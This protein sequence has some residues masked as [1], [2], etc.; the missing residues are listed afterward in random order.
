[1]TG[2]N[3]RA[4]DVNR[5]LAAVAEAGGY[6]IGLGSQRA[7]IAGGRLDP[8]V[9]A[10]YM[11][12]DV[13]PTT[14]IFANLGAVQAAVVPTAL[15]DEMVK[16]VGA[17]ALCLHLN[18]AQ[19]MIQPGGDRDF[20]GCLDG[21]GRLAS[22]L[23]VPVI[24]KETGNGLSRTTAEQ[25]ARV[26][27]EHI[28]VSGAGGT[29]WVGVETRRAI[30]QK[31]EL[32]ELFWDWGIPTAAS[33]LQVQ[34]G[35]FQTVIASGGIYSGLDVAKAIALGADAAGMAR[36]LLQ[37]LDVGGVEGA[38]QRLKWV[39]EELRTAMLLTGSRTVAQLK[40]VARNMAP[41]LSSWVQV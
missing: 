2:G 9:G 28:D 4:G 15:V 31:R 33:L 29:S 41:E 30:G 18:P 27:V 34:G 6:P 21:I 32:G 12:R 7:M 10:S 24:V 22:E 11:L 1:M 36:P 13:A 17:S 20:R 35:R 37:A 8:K 14:P 16:F 19:E 5:L 26:G 25:L 38:L 39:E 3:T 23:S 40:K